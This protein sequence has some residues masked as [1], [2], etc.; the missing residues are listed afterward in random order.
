MLEAAAVASQH[1]PDSVIELNEV[2]FERVARQMHLEWGRASPENLNRM[3]QLF[4]FP[5]P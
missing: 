1:P 5:E 3:L 2:G 4:G